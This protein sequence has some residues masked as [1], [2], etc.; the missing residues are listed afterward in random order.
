MNNDTTLLT[1]LMLQAEVFCSRA[2]SFGPIDAQGA[3]SDE[4]LLKISQCRGAIAQLQSYY[5]QDL[6]GVR[7]P[8]SLAMFRQLVMSLMW[9]A[10]YTRSSIDFR[11]FRTLVQI[12]S[13]LTFLMINELS[14]RLPHQ[15]D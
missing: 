10:F 13:S 6:L 14:K 5:E 15:D 4:L 1:E 7:H 9:V 12:E 11:L 8:A 3:K 2:E